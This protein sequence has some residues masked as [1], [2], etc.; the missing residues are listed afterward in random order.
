MAI[1]E[2]WWSRIKIK[3]TSKWLNLNQRKRMFQRE[4]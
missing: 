4:S 2:P 3:Q 1:E